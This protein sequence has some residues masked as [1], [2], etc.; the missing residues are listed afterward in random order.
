[1]VNQPEQRKQW[2]DRVRENWDERS[3]WWDSMSEENAVSADRAVDL[4]RREEIGQAAGGHDHLGRHV[5]ARE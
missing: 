2:L 5:A 4:D 1:M 3:D